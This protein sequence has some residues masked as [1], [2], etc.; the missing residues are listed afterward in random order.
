MQP[1][2]TGRRRLNIARNCIMKKAALD[3]IV[4]S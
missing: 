3:V 4:A 1:Q 2:D